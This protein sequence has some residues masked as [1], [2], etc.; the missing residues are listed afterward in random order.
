MP[1]PLD[2]AAHARLSSPLKW[3]NNDDGSMSSAEGYAITRQGNNPDY[4]TAFRPGGIQP[5]N[6]LAAGAG[7]FGLAKCISACGKHF[8]T[9]RGS[10]TCAS[11]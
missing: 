4:W 3:S 8:S 7:D 11:K 1:G 6:E 2:M 9:N 10:D 5:S